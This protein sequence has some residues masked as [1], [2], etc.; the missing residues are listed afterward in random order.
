[1]AGT[2]SLS[3]TRNPHTTD[4]LDRWIA[5]MA[6]TDI[7]DSEKS[8]MPYNL[9]RSDFLSNLIVLNETEKEHPTIF[10][11]TVEVL[12]LG[13]NAST[14]SIILEMYRCIDAANLDRLLD[15]LKSKPDHIRFVSHTFTGCLSTESSKSLV[16][17]LQHMN[18]KTIAL[19]LR[20]S[21]NSKKTIEILK[22]FSIDPLT[23]QKL[24]AFE[25]TS[26]PSK[27]WM[28]YTEV[29]SKQWQIVE[30]HPLLAA[31]IRKNGIDIIAWRQIPDEVWAIHP[32]LPEKLVKYQKKLNSKVSAYTLFNF[33]AEESN[34]FVCKLLKQEP[35]KIISQTCF[36]ALIKIHCHF[37]EKVA[38]SCLS[39]LTVFDSKEMPEHLLFLREAPWTSKCEAILLVLEKFYTIFPAGII[40][41]SIQQLPSMWK[42]IFI[43]FIEEG[44][45][46]PERID[47]LQHFICNHPQ[48]PLVDCFLSL[49]KHVP[50]QDAASL[51]DFLDRYPR[52]IR[53]LLS[54]LENKT[55]SS[56]ESIFDKISPSAIKNHPSLTAN[57]LILCPALLN[58][59][60]SLLDDQDII[61]ALTDLDQHLESSSRHFIFHSTLSLAGRDEWLTFLSYFKEDPDLI[62]IVKAVGIQNFVPKNLSAN[63]TLYLRLLQA[64]PDHGFT[65]NK[66]MENADFRK[67]MNDIDWDKLSDPAL[68]VHYLIITTMLVGFPALQPLL[69]WMAKN[70][71]R[72]GEALFDMASAGYIPEALMIMNILEKN[73]GHVQA[74][75]LLKIADS[76]HGETIQKTLT[77]DRTISVKT[78]TKKLIPSAPN[79]T[80]EL[81]LNKAI[82]KI[83]GQ[84][85]FK[86]LLKNQAIE[87]E[88][89]LKVA[90]I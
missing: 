30:D 42:W 46:Y 68:F 88:L 86:Q 50:S 26:D 79:P 69:I 9:L 39:L 54:Y 15:T 76:I 71:Y 49:Q 78:T 11:K 21:D 52:C 1:M 20:N 6:C 40:E 12:S 25:A 87:I 66:L 32:E 90:N 73:P 36:E 7:T 3:P 31:F 59:N 37:G 85:F 72:R 17:Q 18:P 82:E 61:K 38:N 4:L 67:L 57:F 16:S 70:D 2:R 29:D 24:L 80:L 33:P 8:H 5:K 48:A 10:A 23:T 47:N 19:I 41:K 58:T 81:I 77:G 60:F 34:P 75:Q 64:Q 28:N 13:G 89:S 62:D 84:T 14:L 65:I 27:G 56:P 63:K 45:T 51:I 22:S 43:R 44:I 53:P 55:A 74:L 35:I 83:V